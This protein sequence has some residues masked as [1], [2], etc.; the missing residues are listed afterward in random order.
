MALADVTPK[1]LLPI[2]QGSWGCYQSFTL[3][4]VWGFVGFFVDCWRTVTWEEIGCEASEWLSGPGAVFLLCLEAMFFCFLPFCSEH[5]AKHLQAAF[6]Y[7]GF[8]QI[9]DSRS[10]RW[11][12]FIQWLLA[13]FLPFS[14]LLCFPEEGS[15]MPANYIVKILLPDDF[16]YVLK[17]E[18]LA[19]DYVAKEGRKYFLCFWK[20][21]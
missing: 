12:L 6:I 2:I 1:F 18:T 8:P 16:S 17:I 11:G 19:G 4:S 5:F 9:S 13:P 15:W 3:W 21:W 10:L 20:I 14:T 7:L